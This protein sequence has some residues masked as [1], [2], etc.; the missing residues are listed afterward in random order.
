MF[1]KLI[2]LEGKHRFSWI[3]MIIFVQVSYKKK[4]DKSGN[5][6]FT[7][8]NGISTVF[9]I[10][11]DY[12]SHICMILDPIIHTIASIVVFPWHILFFNCAY[13]YLF[14]CQ[15]CIGTMMVHIFQKSI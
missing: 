9:I 7:V 12:S 8:N 14:H 15:A 3:S 1:Y 5:V 2:D 13:I 11:A 4:N 10:Q 6:F